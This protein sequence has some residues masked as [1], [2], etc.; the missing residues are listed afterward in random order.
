[1][2]LFLEGERGV[3]KS[4]L[5]R[6]ALES[7]GSI[8][9][10]FAVER[11]HDRDDNTVGFRAISIDGELPPVDGRETDDER[12]IFLYKGESRPEILCS[13]L[14]RVEVQASDPRC[15]LILL[16][17]IGGIELGNAEVMDILTRLLSGEKPCIGVWK[18]RE[19]LKGMLER[20]GL[21]GDYLMKHRLLEEKIRQR[22][23][24]LEFIPESR[25][26]IRLE[27]DRFLQRMQDR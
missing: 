22:G 26:A 20:R 4:T 7:Y 23:R 27:V 12:G 10:G 13:V 19:N 3:G 24:M 5:L 16:D 17:E 2:H 11:L 1:M 6:T 15:R 8:L 21:S 14:E 25:E 18:S 9:G